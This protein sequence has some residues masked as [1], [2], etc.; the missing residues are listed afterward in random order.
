MVENTRFLEGSELETEKERILKEF[1]NLW[2]FGHSDFYDLIVKMAEIHE[3][4]NKGY[5]IGNP[6]GNFEESERFGIPA[7]KGCLVRMSDKWMRLCNMA[8]KVDDPV[9][10]DAVKLESLEDT[11]IDLANYSL[12]C[13]ILLKEAKKQ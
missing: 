3:I 9:Y 10:Q 7:W 1:K 5:G 12:L 2:R 11:L 8:V 4:K 6:L 13:L